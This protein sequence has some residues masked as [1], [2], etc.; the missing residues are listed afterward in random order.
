MKEN[1]NTA[2]L[3]G[4]TVVLG[5]TGGI[6]A[7][8]SAALTSLS[9]IHIYVNGY[10]TGRHTGGYLPFELD[11]TDAVHDGANELTVAVKDRS[12]TSYHAKGKQK[13]K[14]GGMFYTAQSGIWQTVW[15]EYVPEVYITELEG[16][17]AVSYTHLDVYKRQDK[18]VS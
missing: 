11:I 3:K 1:K 17:P 14:A 10:Q 2:M 6:A 8:K 12:D 7:Y 9:L 5:V 13:L 15:M 18:E 4:K 16:I